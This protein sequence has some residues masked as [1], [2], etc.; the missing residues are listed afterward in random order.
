[1][2]LFG[3]G[4]PFNRRPYP[5]GREDLALRDGVRTLV[6]LRNG[7]EAVR[8]G[9]LRMGAISGK[10]FAPIRYD[11][12]E[13]VVLLVNQS[14]VPVSASI[15]PSLL[16]KGEDGEVPMPLSGQYTELFTGE[17]LKVRSVLSALVPA[18][19]YCIYRKETSL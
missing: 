7:C 13:C 15:Y 6:G 16:Y 3:G 11:E 12:Q 19:G 2:G 14:A 9:R 4:D 8:S 17:S 10:C 1:M 5:W 18:E